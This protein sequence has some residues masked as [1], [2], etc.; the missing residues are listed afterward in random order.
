MR[1]GLLRT[2]AGKDKHLVRAVNGVSFEIRR[3]ETLGLIGESGCGKSTLARTILRLIEPTSGAIWFDGCEVLALD[4]DAMKGL[5][6]RMQIIFQDPYASLNPRRNVEEI[7]GLPLKLH[8]RLSK[9]QIR[10]RV[11]AMIDRVGL[12]TEHLRRYPHQFSGGQRQRIGIAR[13]LVLRPD[14][15]VCDE[16]VSALDVSIQAQIIQLLSELKRELALTY[17]FISHDLSVVAYV[18]D[19]IAVMYL[20]QIVEIADVESLLAQPSHPYTQALLS[21][22]PRIGQAGRG[23]RV[24]LTG[25]L[26]SPMDLPSGCTFHTRC[27]RAMEKCRTVAPRTVALNDSHEVVCHLYGDAA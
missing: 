26:P 15:I 23:D 6:Q 1:R 7:V 27:P 19:R 9:S 2:F 13:A 4:H 12:S 5:R 11:A 25:D 14:F 21:A 22:L 24:K 20:G 3:G 8:E 17:I 18:S 10:D 16:P